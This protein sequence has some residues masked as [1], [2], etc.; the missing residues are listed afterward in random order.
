MIFEAVAVAGW[1][2]GKVRQ[3][4]KQHPAVLQRLTR[5]RTAVEAILQSRVQVLT[6]PPALVEQALALS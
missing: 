2:P 4:L 3:R 6:I 1:A 5:F